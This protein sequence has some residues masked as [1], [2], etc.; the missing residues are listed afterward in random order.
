MYLIVCKREA[1]F[2]YTRQVHPVNDTTL[3]F[4]IQHVSPKTGKII[5]APW[6]IHTPPFFAWL[7]HPLKLHSFTSAPWVI[8][9][10]PFC[11]LFLHPAWLYRFNLAPW[12]MQTPPF[13]AWL[14]HPSWLLH[15]F[16]LL[17]LA[18]TPGWRFFDDWLF[19]VHRL[20]HPRRDDDWGI[21]AMY[22]S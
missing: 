13:T 16:F 12:V 9:T 11:A 18:L 4:T 6:V 5:F 17:M 7:L 22:C 8:H 19:L 1:T 20:F 10:P 21:F 15:R 14:V 3:G 2:L